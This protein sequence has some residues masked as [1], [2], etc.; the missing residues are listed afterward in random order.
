MRIEDIR[1]GHVYKLTGLLVCVICP[2]RH[3]PWFF[4]EFLDGKR[5][6]CDFWMLS[7]AS[8]EEVLEYWLHRGELVA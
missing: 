2:V 8:S 4:V 6:T 1:V 7:E 3:F 5:E